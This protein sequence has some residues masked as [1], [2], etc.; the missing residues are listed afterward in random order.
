MYILI[1][2]FPRLVMEDEPELLRPDDVYNWKHSVHYP[3]ITHTA[4]K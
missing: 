4:K 2:Q 3:N 1:W